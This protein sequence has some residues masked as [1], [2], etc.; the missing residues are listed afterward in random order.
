MDANET[1]FIGGSKG[2]SA[3]KLT[4]RRLSSLPKKEPSK[5]KSILGSVLNILGSFTEFQELIA[6]ILFY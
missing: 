4:N 5:Q 2:E 1:N 3:R 6:H